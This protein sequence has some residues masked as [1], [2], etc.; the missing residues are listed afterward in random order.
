MSGMQSQNQQSRSETAQKSK[1]KKREA[2]QMPLLFRCLLVFM[3]TLSIIFFATKLVEYNRLKQ[4]TDQLNE[5]I[6]DHEQNAAE[7]RYLI[8]SPIDDAYI[9]R[10]A[11]DRL[12][13]VFPDEE[14]FYSNLPQED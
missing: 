10:I 2:L 6:K 5:E 11:R 13:L 3:L 1:S 7:L 4:E 12:G 14:V 9:I 8:D